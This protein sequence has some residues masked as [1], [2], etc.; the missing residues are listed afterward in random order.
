MREVAQEAVRQ[1]IEQQSR[2][3]LLEEVLALSEPRAAPKQS[4]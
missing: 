2:A 4:C 1:Y 3:H